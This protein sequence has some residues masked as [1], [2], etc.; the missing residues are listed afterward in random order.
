MSHS[1]DIDPGNQSAEAA[2]PG[3][4]ALVDLLYG[5]LDGQARERAERRVRE[6]DALAGELEALSRIRSI[7]RELPDEEPPDALSTK[8]LHAAAAQVAGNRA[9]VSDE[10]R[11]SVWERLRRLFMPLMMHPGLAAAASVILIGGVAGMLYV[12]NNLKMA[13]P[14]AREAGQAAPAPQ[15]NEAERAAATTPADTI[16]AQ[17]DFGAPQAGATGTAAAADPAAVDGLRGRGGERMEALDEARDRRPEGAIGSGSATYRPPTNAEL[18]LGDDFGA[19]EQSQGYFAQAPAEE[20]APGTLA[21]QQKGGKDGRASASAGEA[22]TAG[23]IGLDKSASPSTRRSDEAKQKEAES[24]RVAQSTSPR[25]KARSRDGDGAGYD[26]LASQLETGSS[27]GARS[28][29]APGASGGAAGGAPAQAA[30]APQPAPA[31]PGPAEPAPPKTA[32]ARKPS[33]E[34]AA[35]PPPPADDRAPEPRPEAT[36][37]DDAE[38]GAPAEG[39]K[40]TA[41]KAESDEARNERARKDTAARVLALHKQALAAAARGDCA[42]VRSTTSTIRS[43]D[44]AYHRENVARDARLQDCLAVKK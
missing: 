22:D 9:P 40:V 17:P 18:A 31:S 29:K 1:K 43:L 6:D 27:A 7:M 37:D 8:L 42:T 24:A 38:A 19:E 25:S 3:D 5:E 14:M 26:E 41:R 44:Q 32:P 11:P 10:E 15:A 30:P 33:P 36:T 2:D 39:K 23:L 16:T 4:L 28:G 20:P 12:S 35:A 34:R 13:S 21:R